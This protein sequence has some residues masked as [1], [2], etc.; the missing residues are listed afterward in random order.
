M[1]K[2]LKKYIVGFSL[3]GI[4][5]TGPIA[6]SS[7]FAAEISTENVESISVEK[8]NLD[9][10]KKSLN[11]FVN[12]MNNGD[13]TLA[14]SY[15]ED[16]RVYYDDVKNGNE[17]KASLNSYDKKEKVKSK[18]AQ[19]VKQN[20]QD[21]ANTKLL[22]VTPDGTDSAKAKFLISENERKYMVTL[23]VKKINGEWKLIVDGT[24][25]PENQ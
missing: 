9:Q 24:A 3:L 5:T 20:D 11:E 22:S 21:R 18:Y 14:A 4:M 2:N 23:P 16:V 8:D 6:S 13:A 1:N 12:A 10:V 25:V 17:G 15:V 19:Y 7:V